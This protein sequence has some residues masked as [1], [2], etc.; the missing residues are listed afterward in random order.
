MSSAVCSP[1]CQNG[2]L[3][4]APNTCNC[5]GTGYMGDQCE[6]LTCMLLTSRVGQVFTTDRIF[7]V[8]Y[9]VYYS[10]SEIYPLCL[11][12]CAVQ[13]ARMEDF[14]LPQTHA[15]VLA[16]D[17]WETNVKHVC[18][19]Q[20]ELSKCSILIE[21]LQSPISCIIVCLKYILYVF[22]FVQSNLPEWRTLLCPKHMQLYWHWIHWRPM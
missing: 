11:Q 3:C 22:S 12:L 18:Y 15:T 9:F 17:T 20:V 14:A 13:L 7:A 16:L 2:G 21:Y 10:L 19:L 5:T 6:I 8:T 1:T 4:S